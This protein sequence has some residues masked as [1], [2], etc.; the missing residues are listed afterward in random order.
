LF[1]LMAL[2]QPNPQ[3]D[4]RELRDVARR[5]RTPHSRTVL[6][7]TIPGRG[8]DFD[9]DETNESENAEQ[10]WTE[11]PQVILADPAEL[12]SLFSL[13]HLVTT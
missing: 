9:W 7:T 13:D 5:V 11:P 6:I 4:L 12:A 3:A 8:E 2:L 1:D 10:A